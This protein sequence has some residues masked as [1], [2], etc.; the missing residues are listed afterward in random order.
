MILF[1]RVCLVWVFLL[2]VITDSARLFLFKR[3]DRGDLVSL[4]LVQRVPL[5]YHRRFR[6]APFI[7]PVKSWLYCDSSC[8]CGLLTP[9]KKLTIWWYCAFEYH[10]VLLWVLFWV[11]F[12]G[13]IPTSHNRFHW[14]PSKQGRRTMLIP[15]FSELKLCFLSLL[16]YRSRYSPP[17][18]RP[19]N[20]FTTVP[21]ISVPSTVLFHSVLISVDNLLLWFTFLA[22]AFS[23][24]ILRVPL[25]PGEQPHYDVASAVGSISAF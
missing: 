23:T 5:F 14:S 7:Q 21:T 22:F 24:S 13:A 10:C 6:L 16:P 8:V 25:F 9:T 20:Y 18:A 11:V 19:L 1:L 12:L 4:G 15:D 2:F 3:T 17:F